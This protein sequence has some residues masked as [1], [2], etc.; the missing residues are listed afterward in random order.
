MLV[1]G[2]FM[3]AAL[4]VLAR[5]IKKGRKR[6]YEDSKQGSEERLKKTR[7]ETR[8]RM[9]SAGFAEQML[10]IAAS[11]RELLEFAGNP[12]GFALLEEG[13]TVRLGS[14]A[15]EIRIEY[16]IHLA[17]TKC[18]RKGGHPLGSWRVSGPGAEEREFTELGDVVVYLKRIIEEK[19][20]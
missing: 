15:G 6:T 17:Q 20:H 8:E 19:G 18:A 16:G 2:V 13:R 10:P 11:V 1:M 4:F 14:P 9:F 3:F 7:A 12:A 5:I